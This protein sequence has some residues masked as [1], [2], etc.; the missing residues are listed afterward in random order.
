MS[1]IDIIIL[2]FLL[3]CAWLGYRFGI[4]RMGMAL[5]GIVSSVL[6][7]NWKWEDMIFYF[8]SNNI[9]NPYILLLFMFAVITLITSVFIWVSGWMERFFKLVFLN[10]INRLAGMFL[11][12]KVGFVLLSFFIIFT[13]LVPPDNPFITKQRLENSVFAEMVLTIEKHT[14]I[15]QLVLKNFEQMKTRMLDEEEN[16]P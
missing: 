4:V 10:W 15:N 14:S 16:H 9:Q 1:K 11:A 3:V 6:I 13:T 12:M 2:F 7:L 5:A 8:H